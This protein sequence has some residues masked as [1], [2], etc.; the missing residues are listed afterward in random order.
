MGLFGGSSK[1]SSR[2]DPKIG[3]ANSQ[4]SSAPVVSGAEDINFAGNNDA[5]SNFAF[6]RSV[7]KAYAPVAQEGSNLTLVNENSV[8]LAAIAAG[9][10]IHA[11]DL[12]EK[13]SNQN[14]AVTNQA[15]SEAV[16]AASEAFHTSSE[17]VSEANKSES[18]LTTEKIVQYGGLIMLA[19][20]IMKSRLF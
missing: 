10:S 19:T 13:S 17:Q 3:T 8:D 2:V 1:S 16:A 18:F 20:I 12:I 9:V 7:S 5:P 15:T 14:L 6:G 11:M 4:L